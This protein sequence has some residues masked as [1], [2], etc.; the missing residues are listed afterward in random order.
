MSLLYQR[1]VTVTRSSYVPTAGQPLEQQSVTVYTA[2][3]ARIYLKRDKGFSS[4]KEFPGQ[5]TTSASTPLWMMDARVAD[6]T[7]KDADQVVDDLGRIFK[8]DAAYFN[9]MYMECALSPATPEA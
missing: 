4:P 6:G 3:P 1:T 2:L 7:I 5:T 9:G 8:V